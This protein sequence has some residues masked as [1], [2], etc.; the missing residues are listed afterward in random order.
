[1]HVFDSSKKLIDD[2]LFVNLLENIGSD[3]RMKICLCRSQATGKTP[4]KISL[5]LHSFCISTVLH[6]AKTE[7]RRAYP[8]CTPMA[9]HEQKSLKREALA[10]SLLTR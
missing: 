1:M 7:L 6:L 8:N 2:V 9:C 10:G 5:T 3:Y 4:Q